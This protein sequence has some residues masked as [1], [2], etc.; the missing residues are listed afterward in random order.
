MS[1]GAK[2]QRS[3][4][5]GEADEAYLQESCLGVRANPDLGGWGPVGPLTG[6]RKLESQEVVFPL[7]TAPTPPSLQSAPSSRTTQAPTHLCVGMG[8][9]LCFS[10][11]AHTPHSSG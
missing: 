11:F 10:G 1:R 8:S 9:L 3:I 5:V 6:C 7:P 4:R 2:R